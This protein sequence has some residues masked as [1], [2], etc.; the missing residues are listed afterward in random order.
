VSFA[1]GR[2]E[3]NGLGDG[4]GAGG[5]SWFHFSSTGCSAALTGEA[6][7]ATTATAKAATATVAAA[8]L[9]QRLKAL[10]PD[11]SF[12]PLGRALATER[13]S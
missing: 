7:A 13:K 8:V 2:T 1:P 4:G 5:T 6:C 11:L 9:K 3:K 10:M 12:E